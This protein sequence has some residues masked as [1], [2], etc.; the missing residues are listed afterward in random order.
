MPRDIS[1]PQAGQL[2]EVHEPRLVGEVIIDN[3]TNSNEP[4]Y[5]NLRQYIAE[6]RGRNLCQ[7][8]VEVGAG[9]S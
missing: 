8:L 3:L 9:G 1:K 2:N 4:L 7:Y 6:G 5:R